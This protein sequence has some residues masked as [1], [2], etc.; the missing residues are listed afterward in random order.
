MKTLTEEKMNPV[1]QLEGFFIEFD[2]EEMTELREELGRRGY[3]ADCAGI[4]EAMLDSLFEEP[5]A[6]SEA[7]TNTE[8]VIKKARTFV[9]ENPATV[10]FGLDLISGISKKIFSSRQRR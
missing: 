3:T 1:R 7:E 2:E 8:R 6:E 10:K 9:Q 4:K 5:D